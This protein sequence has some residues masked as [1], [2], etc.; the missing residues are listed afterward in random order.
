MNNNI[1][2]DEQVDRAL[3]STDGWRRLGGRL[4]RVMS[5]RDFDEAL[6]FFQR[7]ADAAQDYGR[8]PDMAISHTNSVRLEIE[9]LHH[10][11]F[12]PAEIRLASKV[13]AVVQEQH[14]THISH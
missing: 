13:D 2:T 4:V 6:R 12:T 8:R 10:A 11:G 7:V 5:F 14:P 9:N 1:L 3:A